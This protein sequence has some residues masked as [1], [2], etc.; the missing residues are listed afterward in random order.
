MT[1]LP[2]GVFLPLVAESVGASHAP[3]RIIEGDNLSVLEALLPEE[4]GTFKLAYIDPP[5]NTGKR[6]TYS[7]IH[8]GD[9]VKMMH[10]R[11]TRIHAL[12]RA[13]GAIVVHID[14]HEQARL[15]LLLSE[16]FGAD[17][18]L[19]TIVWDKLNPK[20][21]ARGIANQHEYILCWAKDRHRF[22]AEH[23]LLRVKPNAARMLDYAKKCMKNLRG[24]S[25]L[26]S[27]NQRFRKWIDQQSNLRGGEAAY[28][29]ID[30][31]GRVFQAVSMAWPNKRRPPDAYFEPLTHPVTGLPCPVPARGWRNP[32]ATMASLLAEQRVV[33]GKDHKTQPRRKYFLDE[34]MMEKIPSVLRDGSCDDARLMELGT[35]FEHAKPLSV[36]R[37]LVRWFT[38]DAGDKVLDA[39]AGS[40]TAG[41]AVLAEN[42]A[43][44]ACL[45]FTLI[46]APTPIEPDT[47]AAKAGFRDVA[48]LTGARIRAV[49]AT[50]GTTEAQVGF[51]ASRWSE[52]P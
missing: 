45:V 39:F 49:L 14:E 50:V 8:D 52:Y 4:K 40:G 19:G 24:A 43:R 20:G 13:D 9:W 35:P 17:Q 36:A 38:Q 46:Q 15:L 7:D 33:F 47:D 32:P 27:A 11:L 16:I 37:R 6:F 1:G 30:A 41:H 3:H 26:E 51:V 44:D 48:Q 31:D 22:L 34:H 18:N 10:V 2:P 12:L 42:T 25:D 21:D 29:R 23:P 28:R 5:Y